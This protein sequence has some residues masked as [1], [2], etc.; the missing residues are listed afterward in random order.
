MTPAA[1]VA[2]AIGLLDDIL[3][4]GPPEKLLTGWGRANRYAGSGDRAAV[5]DLVYDA[6]RQRRS[7][8]ALG[9]TETGRGL[10]IGWARAQGQDAAALFD[11][12]RHGPD[13]LSPE[14][15]AAGRAP[16][17]GAEALDCPDWLWPLLCDD[18]GADDARASLDA[19][20]HRAPVHLR[21]NAARAD[22]DSVAAALGA[23]G[24]ACVPHPLSPTALEIRGDGRRLRSDPRVL[25]GT[26]EFQDAASQAVADMVPLKPGGRLLDYCAGGGGKTL[27][28]GARV[29]GVFVAHDA[30]PRR[31]ADLPARAARA[32]LDVM[33]RDT[34]ALGAEPPF[35]TV[36][37]DAPCSGSGSW[38]RD[39]AGKWALTPARLAELCAL[40]DEI[41]G[42]AVRH[43]RPGGHLVHV[44]CSFIEEENAGTVA[45][46]L[47]AHPD[48]R[49]LR[50]RQWLPA[51]GGDGFFA[52]I[53]AAGAVPG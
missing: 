39:P 16:M 8:A 12:S 15:V 24:F 34:A 38:R 14:E 51:D 3:A 4:G 41:L 9:G 35:D 27:A 19:L 2:A 20:R 43:V 32:G 46:F 5:R 21:V 52:A 31:M 7:L 45:R 1:R 37:V 30:Q 6:L 44:T 25:D 53:L 11:G 49:C 48:W 33:L 47:A 42:Q 28:I 50:R 18:L 13:P 17:D 26:V 23:A 29:P 36:L 22:R 10:M 40:Q